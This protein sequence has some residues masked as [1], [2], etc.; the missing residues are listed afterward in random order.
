MRPLGSIRVPGQCL[1]HPWAPSELGAESFQAGSP[2]HLSPRLTRPLLF[3]FLGEWNAAQ[4]AEA[5]STGGV[6]QRAGLPGVLAWDLHPGSHGP[7]QGAR[8]LQPRRMSSSC[9]ALSLQ[10]AR[11]ARRQGWASAHSGSQG[12]SVRRRSWETSR[13]GVQR[14][15]L[16]NSWPFSKPCTSPRVFSPQWM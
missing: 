6:R 11:R 16:L 7:H 4:R 5:N 15:F 10:G 13:G 9:S 8:L 14:A 12:S 2:C 3:F 1:L